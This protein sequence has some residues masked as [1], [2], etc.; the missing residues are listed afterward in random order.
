MVALRK[1]KNLGVTASALAVLV[2]SRGCSCRPSVLGPAD[3]PDFASMSWRKVEGIY[4]VRTGATRKTF[5]RFAIDDRESVDALRRAL[6]C[7][8]VSGLMTGTGRQLVI[9]MD[10]G[11]V[12]QG[13][14]VFE[15]RIHL[16]LR[17]DNWYSYCLDLAD[18]GFHARLRTACLEHEK[19]IT[20]SATLDHIILRGNLD[21][22]C[23][24]IIGNAQS[25]GADGGAEAVTAN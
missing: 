13:S 10:D 11:E 8:E 18:S 21:I 6:N 24:K 16:G 25:V 23:Y 4:W 3:K 17:R 7:E 9:T 5:R 1:M 22:N 12:W 19:G 14:V 2:F 15:N 20:P